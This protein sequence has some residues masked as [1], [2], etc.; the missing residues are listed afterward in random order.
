MPSLKVAVVSDLHLDVSFSLPSPQIPDDVDVVLIAG[1]VASATA[2]VSSNRTGKYM[3]GVKRPT[4]VIAG[5]HDYYL[6]SIDDDR[7]IKEAIEVSPLVRYLHKDVYDL[8]HFRIMGVPLWAS[9][10]WSEVNYTPETTC[11]ILPHAVSCGHH[12]RTE[13]PF[14]D[15]VKRLY[16]DQLSWLREAVQKTVDDGKTPVA[17]THFAP[18][19]HS[20][21]YKYKGNP[22]NPYFVNNL[23]D[24]DPLFQQVAF[25]AHGHTHTSFDYVVGRT[26]VIC[27]PRGYHSEN[28][29]YDSALTLTIEAFP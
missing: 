23:P 21:A 1:D 4:L 14:V 27:N 5:N 7:A 8:E 16:H 11:H 28:R 10:D 12:I 17:L 13:K 6:Q 2:T 25:W 18:S 9:L 3:R 20:L 22:I 15:E 29:E 26:R 19:I 24:D